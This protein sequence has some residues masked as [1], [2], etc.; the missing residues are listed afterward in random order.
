M[1]ANNP[2]RFQE[3]SERDQLWASLRQLRPAIDA[4]V[5]GGFDGSE[6]QRQIIQVLVRVIAAEL[7]FRAREGNAALLAMRVCPPGTPH[8]RRKKEPFS[9][10]GVLIGGDISVPKFSPT[11]S[12]DRLPMRSA[13]QK[14]AD[15]DP[16]DHLRT[17]FCTLFPV[18]TSPAYRFPFESIARSC[19]Q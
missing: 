6:R 9:R 7:D 18:S 1:S 4:L 16:L 3:Q 15:S 10:C 5:A 11:R 12:G 17:N 2:D 19:T 13:G 8:P 14:S